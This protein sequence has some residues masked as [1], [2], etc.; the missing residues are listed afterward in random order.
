HRTAPFEQAPRR[1]PK[2]S[3]GDPRP[4]RRRKEIER[5]LI[6]TE[7]ACGFAHRSGKSARAAREI[8]ETAWRM[9]RGT[10]GS[11]E[12][13][14]MKQRL[15][16]DAGD[17][18]ARAHASGQIA[19]GFH[20]LERGDDGAAREVV[21]MRQAA[22]RW[23]ADAGAQAAV[24]DRLTQCGAELPV[25]RRRGRARPQH[26]RQLAERALHNWSN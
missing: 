1:L 16:K 7:R 23:K 21:A 14:R 3:S 8:G 6:R 9:R 4:E 24:E 13:T 20:L 10:A 11:R 15:G 5:R 2:P 18:G 25:R 12:G 17:E 22:R 19:F 26:Y